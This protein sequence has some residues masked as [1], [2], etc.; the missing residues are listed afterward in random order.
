MR[1][2]QDFLQIRFGCHVFVVRVV[3]TMGGSIR[4]SDLAGVAF[5]DC[6]CD[7]E[8]GSLLVTAGSAAWA[9]RG[10]RQEQQAE[11]RSNGTRNYRHTE[12]FFLNRGRQESRGYKFS[13]LGRLS[14]PKAIGVNGLLQEALGAV[15]TGQ[16]EK[17]PFGVVNASC[18]TR[19]HFLSPAP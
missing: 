11:Q 4:F 15:L 16:A 7:G 17:M 19:A 6:C 13:N 2:P 10:G 18:E 3:A 5:G 9:T 12:N 14:V 1:G 8:D